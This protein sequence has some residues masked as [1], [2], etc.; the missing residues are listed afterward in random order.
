MSRTGRVASS[1]A[2]TPSAVIRPYCNNGPEIS[3]AIER[4]KQRNQSTS[5]LYFI[6]VIKKASKP[7]ETSVE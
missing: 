6:K 7:Q 4:N 5:E 1:H 2:A 3:K